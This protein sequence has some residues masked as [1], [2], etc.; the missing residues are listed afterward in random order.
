[1][2]DD[3]RT[4]LIAGL[5]ATA[6]AS[7]GGGAAAAPATVETPPPAL[8][9]ALRF[10]AEARDAAAEDF[11]HILRTRPAA[12]LLPAA[13]DD[14][15]AT[16]RWAAARGLRLAPR[17]QGHSVY[18]RAMVRDGI[19]AEMS[20]LR[21]IHGV[22]GDRVEVDAGA[23]WREVVGA[24]LPRGLV[25]PVLTDYL[26]LSVGGTLVVGGVGAAISRFGAQSDNVLA[27][28][29]VTGEGRTL[30]CSPERD[31]ALFDAVRAGLGQVAI[32]TRATLRL[33]P[34]PRQVRRFLLTY[35]D[36]TAMLQD[37]RRLAEDGRFDTVQGAILAAPAGGGTGPSGSTPWQTCPGRRRCIPAT[38]PCWP[39]CRTIRPVGKR[40]PWT[41]L[42]TSTDSRG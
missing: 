40:P 3:R 42:T 36:L 26:G 32:V 25:P 24:T 39:D 34:A 1:M 19:V 33:V 6:A 27:M 35:P 18:G 17:G 11:G 12:V 5:A 29:V 38:T 2:D 30:A 28:E 13:A 20:R 7:M 21:T 10:D 14:L 4:V 15:A 16:I 41:T 37:A 23:T 22:A 9:G 8:D 31:A